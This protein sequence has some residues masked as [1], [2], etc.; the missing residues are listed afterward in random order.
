[1]MGADSNCDPLVL[2]PELIR[3]IRD[4]PAERIAEL[5]DFVDFLRLRTADRELT[6]AATRMS[7]DALRRV[8]DNPEDAEYDRL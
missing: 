2:S 8:W 6:R 4:L 5:E 7:E 3:K 1:M